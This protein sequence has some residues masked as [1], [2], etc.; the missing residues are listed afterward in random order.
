MITPAMRAITSIG[1]SINTT[2][3]LSFAG[4]SEPPTDIATITAATRKQMQKQAHP[5]MQRDAL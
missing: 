4:A 3:I 2:I 5:K 1:V